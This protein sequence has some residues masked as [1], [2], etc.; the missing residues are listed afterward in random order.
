MEVLL[1][2]EDEE[3]DIVVDVVSWRVVVLVVGCVP[4]VEGVGTCSVEGGA[5]GTSR[6]DW[7]V[8]G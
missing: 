6:V 3:D 5:G 7:V 1:G 8:G 2:V 4:F